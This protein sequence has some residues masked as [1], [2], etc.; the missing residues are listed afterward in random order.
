MSICF[1]SIGNYNDKR[2]L[3][4]CIGNTF[5]YFFV[6]NK[7][8]L[9]LHSFYISL[10]YNRYFDIHF[11]C[12][13]PYIFIQENYTNL[14]DRQNWPMLTFLCNFRQQLMTFHCGCHALIV[15]LIFISYF[16]KK[17]SSTPLNNRS[18]SKE[19]NF[20]YL[21]NRKYVAILWHVFYINLCK[22][23]LIFC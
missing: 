22:S 23:C 16:C 9:N 7:R 14:Y 18:C 4:L 20:W 21:I 3:Q 8:I 2:K 13:K 5:L 11:C 15:P 17:F 10:D 6:R 12:K 1:L 19:N